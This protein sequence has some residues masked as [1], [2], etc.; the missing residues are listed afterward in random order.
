MTSPIRFKGKL[1]SVDHRGS[2]PAHV[3]NCKEYTDGNH[4]AELEVELEEVMRAIY[5][6]S[7]LG[8]LEKIKKSNPR[9]E[10]ECICRFPIDKPSKNCIV[11]GS[12]QEREHNVCYA[13]KPDLICDKCGK[14]LFEE[15]PKEAE[16]T[17]CSHLIWKYTTYDYYL[18]NSVV[19]EN[20]TV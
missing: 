17:W 1:Q 8:R 14:K 11:H 12:K 18:H 6:N 16:M 5:E 4:T 19:T 9:S 13:S 2:C 15:N 7:Y 20:W 3:K 10:E